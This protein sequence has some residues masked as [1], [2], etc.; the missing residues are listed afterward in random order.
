MATQ[1]FTTGKLIDPKRVVITGV[2]AV[3]PAGIGVDAL[4]DAV[5]EGR[6][7]ISALETQA[8]RKS[9]V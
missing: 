5:V 7:A 8:D 2:G 9:V 3:S 1:N 4:Y 6:N